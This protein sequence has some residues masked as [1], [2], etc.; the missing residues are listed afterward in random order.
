MLHPILK[1]CVI[2]DFKAPPVIVNERNVLGVD[3]VQEDSFCDVS[4]I[5]SFTAL[6]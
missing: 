3:K 4:V 5:F 6:C 1:S 2:N